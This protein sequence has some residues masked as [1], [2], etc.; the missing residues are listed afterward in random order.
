MALGD[1]AQMNDQA[2]RTADVRWYSRLVRMMKIALPICAVLLIGLIFL[3]GR[4]RGGIVDL[5]TTKDAAALAAGL[6]LE[7]PRFAGVTEGGEPYVLTAATALPDGAVP[8]RIDL[9][10]PIGEITLADE[11]RIKVTSPEGQM[12]RKDEKLSLTGGVVVES[13]DGYRM[14]TDQVDL[15][16][17]AKTALAP[18]RLM[19]EGPR[20]S[21]E[22]DHVRAAQAADGEKPV[23]LW[24]D[25]NVRVI[26]LPSNGETE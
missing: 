9:N 14:V 1:P 13:S 18:G 19:A 7:N 26:Y 10:Q 11:R 21:I 4:E 20:G 17:A 24:F 3:S 16:M 6:E 15:D 5:T 22:A 25:G 8:N 2:R 12:F 23:T